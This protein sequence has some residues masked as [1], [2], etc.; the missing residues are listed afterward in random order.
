MTEFTGQESAPAKDL[1]LDL[2]APA[3]FEQE[4]QVVFVCVD[5]ETYEKNPGLVTELGFAFLDTQKLIDVPPGFGARNWFNLIQGRHIRIKEYSYIKNVE[6]VQGCPD[7][8]M[9]G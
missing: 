7:S 3:P 5:V 6:Y 8:F 1:T 4:R 2:E 9:F